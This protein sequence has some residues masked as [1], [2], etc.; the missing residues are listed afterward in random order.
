MVGEHLNAIISGQL[1]ATPQDSDL[2]TY[3][4]MISKEDGRLDWQQSAIELDRRIRAMT[5]WPGAFTTW[6]GKSLKIKQASLFDA[7][8][9]SGHPGEVKMVGETAV[10]CTGTGTIQLQQL[11]LAG[12]R[13]LPISDFL[14]GRP[15][16]IGAVLGS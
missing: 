11:Q 15:D 13:A 6:Q 8:S 1:T 7:K 4:P 2:S 16:F 9:G 10:V 14:R 3:A 5:P 12:K